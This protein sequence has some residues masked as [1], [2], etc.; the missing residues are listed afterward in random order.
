MNP[1]QPI[2]CNFYDELVLRVMRRM[3][4]EIVYT[5]ATGQQIVVQD[6]ID[7]IYTDEEAEFMRLESGSVLRLDQ[8][9]QVDDIPALQVSFCSVF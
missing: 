1:Y 3:R 9:E 5:D 7:D 6:R 4:S 2:D 8:I